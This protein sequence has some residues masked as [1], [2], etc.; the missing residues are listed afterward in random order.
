MLMKEK[1]LKEWF[2]NPLFY[3]MMFMENDF[4]KTFSVYLHRIVEQI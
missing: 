4:R 3:Y 1:I 2:T